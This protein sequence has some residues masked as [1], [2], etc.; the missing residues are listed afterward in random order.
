MKSTYR[1]A[2]GKL[3][4][5]STSEHKTQRPRWSST[6]TGADEIV[7]K[8][9]AVKRPENGDEF[10][11]STD[12]VEQTTPRQQTGHVKPNK[13]HASKQRRRAGNRYEVK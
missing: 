7:G 2:T 1:G 3:A 5:G 13:R 10:T 6:H 12:R 9:A 8:M 11:E 4:I